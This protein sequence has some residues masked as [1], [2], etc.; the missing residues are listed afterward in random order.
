VKLTA[1]HVVGGTAFIAACAAFI[2]PHEGLR[3]RAY[4][5]PANPRIATIC[6]GQTGADVHFGDTKSPAECRQL[7]EQVL[8]GYVVAVDQ[9]MPGLPD[10]RRIAYTDLIYNGGAGLLTRGRPSIV[11]QERA[12]NWRDACEHVMRFVYAGGK[13]LPG[14]VRRRQQERDLCLNSSANG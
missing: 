8:P 1:K 7:L 4:A 5:D 6:Y 13:V 2:V 3:T 9:L 11:Q 12:G 10:N 14:L